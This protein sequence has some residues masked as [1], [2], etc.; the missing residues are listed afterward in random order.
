MRAWT[1][2]DPKQKKKYGDKCPWSVGWYDPDGN[3][4]QKRIGSHSMA[5]KFRRKIEGELAAGTYQGYERKTWARFREEYDRG[6]LAGMA[7]GNRG[8]TEIALA[9]FERIISPK[10]LRAIRTPIIEKYKATRQAERGVRKGSTVSPAT[11]NKELRHLKAVLR[12]AYDWKYLPEM[13]KIRML[14]EP[15]KLPLYVTPEHF[16]A[17]YKACD[18]AKRPIGL[19]YEPKLWWQGLATFCYMTGW[20]IGES[21][22]LRRQDVDLEAGTAITRHDDNKG[23]REEQIA[24]HPVVIEHLRRL[25]S[26][27]P[28]VFPWYYSRERLWEEFR[29]IQGAAGI[30]LSCREKHEHT[31]SCHVYGFHDFRRG[32]RRRT[33]R[34]FQRTPC[35]V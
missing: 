8:L 24:L 25:P 9:H 33:P 35:N 7:A 27:E 4:K 14:R 23:K 21:L 1:F 29:A 2:Q 11:I 3:R 12:V 28:V 31:P 16:A 6:V 30:H 26:F 5:E 15:E 20:R 13:P 34:G 22:A 32:F 10:Y 19:P 17:I 18:A